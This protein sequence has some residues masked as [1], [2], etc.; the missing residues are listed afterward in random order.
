MIVEQVLLLHFCHMTSSRDVVLEGQKLV[1]SLEFLVARRAGAGGGFWIPLKPGC[2][3]RVALI[4]HCS[5]E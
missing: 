2:P 1:S 5:T 3:T 4:T